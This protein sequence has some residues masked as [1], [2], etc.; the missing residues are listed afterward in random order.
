MSVEKSEVAL[1]VRR[2]LRHPDFKTQA[3]RMGKV[4]RVSRPGISFW[5]Q[6]QSKEE[7]AGW[8]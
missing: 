4:I 5:R 1:F 8:K 2:L 3:N 6:H 7:R